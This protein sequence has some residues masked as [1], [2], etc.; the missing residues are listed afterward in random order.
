MWTGYLSVAGNEIINSPR[1]LAAL[2]AAGLP[3]ECGTSC[4]QTL[5]E[6]LGEDTY[7]AVDESAPWWDDSQPAS[8]GFYG[9]LGVSVTGFNVKPLERTPTPT[10]GDGAI[11]GPLRRPHR[12]VAWTVELFAAGECELSYGLEWLSAA[13]EGSVCGESS[14]SGDS[15]C[16]YSCCP[17][18]NEYETG[19]PGESELRHLY[20]VG[21][22]AGPQLTELEE[23]N[24]ILIATVTFTLGAGKPFIYREE[25][26]TNVG[27]V[28]L[29]QG[30]L[31]PNTDPDQVYQQCQAPKPCA[32]DPL[33]P[34]P[35]MPPRPP[36]P[37]SPCRP[38]GKGTFR[39]SRI[40]VSP[41]DQAAWLETVPVIEVQP[42]SRA[43]RRLIVRFWT[44]GT[45]TPCDD[46]TDP[47]NACTDINVS[48]I[49]AGSRLTIDG[50]VNRSSVECQ[51]FPA[52]V[53]TS[54]PTVYGT[55]GGMFQWP[56]FPCP[57]G[58]CIEVWS[59]A[60]T[61]AADATARVL[62]VPRSDMG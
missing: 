44:N 27:W 54:T 18:E 23:Q 32:E 35:A 58:L 34:K 56:T 36:V 20:D 1:V 2:H 45:N 41:L 55:R 31:V 25:L 28:P 38:T 26:K 52:G 53:A 61:T 51:R 15:L 19:Q 43:L 8:W 37:V 11:L 47:C 5:A 3:M 30:Q 50:R 48:Y 46:F 6:V 33:C 17:G 39:R 10:A 49:P 13:L 24:G 29:G 16:V 59:Q 21:L 7:G 14:C 4:C 42:G 60:D 62:L 57:T 40:H 12:E 22:L 9:V